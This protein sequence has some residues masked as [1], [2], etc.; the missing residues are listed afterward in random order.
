MTATS[1]RAKGTAAFAVFALYFLITGIAI[2]LLRANLLEAMGELE[3]VYQRAEHL[4]AAN[5]ATNCRLIP[6][7]GS[8]NFGS[9]ER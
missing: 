8:Q 7:R 9:R 6:N 5:A 1:L 3:A 2:T 4:T